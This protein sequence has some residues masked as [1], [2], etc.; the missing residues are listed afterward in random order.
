MFLFVYSSS[1]SPR[2]SRIFIIINKFFRRIFP[3]KF[4]SISHDSD[5]LSFNYI[6]S[7]PS[8]LFSHDDIFIFGSLRVAI[9][10]A[11]PA[12]ESWRTSM[13]P[14][15]LIATV[16]NLLSSFNYD[17]VI[18]TFG[19]LIV[20]AN[21]ISSCADILMPQ[22]VYYFAC[23]GKWYFAITWEFRVFTRLTDWYYFFDF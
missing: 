6:C 2:H 12:G 5:F 16:L 8:Q 22:I 14:W 10:P 19:W 17:T 13:I 4:C 3:I 11:P 21:E 18:R 15:F 9:T 23:L 7:H 1:S 20:W